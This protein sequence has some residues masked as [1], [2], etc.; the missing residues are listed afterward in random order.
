MFKA[1]FTKKWFCVIAAELVLFLI[2]ALF[3]SG[4]YSKTEITFSDSDMQLQGTEGDI[5]NGNYL[6][7]SFTEK[8]AVVTPAFQLKKGV[9]YFEASYAEQGI[10]KAGLIYDRTRNGQELVDNDE[11]ILN[12]ESSSISYRVN[13]HDDSALRFKIRLTGDASD[14]DYVQLL[15]VYIVSSRLT[16]V[17]QLFYLAVSFL[18]LD[19]MAWGYMSEYRKWDAKQKMVFITLA[20]TALLIGLPLC[21]KGLPDGP[22]LRFHLQRLEGVYKGLLSGQFPVRI[23]PGWLDGYGYASS[24]FYGD[25]FLYFPAFLR[26]AGF[27]LE[28]AYKCYIWGVA[29]VT[30]ML[31]FYAFKRI[32]KDDLAAMVGTLLYV[33]STEKLSIQYSARLGNYG[34]MMFYPLILAGFYLIFT[35]DEEKAEYKGLWKLLTFGFTGLL[36]THMQSCL[37]VGLYAV[38]G[39]IIM[40]KKVVRKKVFLE[41]LKA[42]GAAILL[43]LWYLVPF[44]NYML[45]ESLNINSAITDGEEIADYYVRL[46]DFMQGGE[47]LHSLIARPNYVDYAI[48]LILLLYIITIPMQKKNTA[49]KR[50]RIIFGLALSAFWACTDLFPAVKIAE[51]CSM[52]VKYFS[53]LQYQIRFISIAVTFAACLAAL[54]FVMDA[55]N[56]EKLYLVAGLLCCAMLYQDLHYFETVVSEVVYLSDADLNSRYGKSRYDYGIGN[57]EFLP[58]EID[59]QKLTMEV[60]AGEALQIENVLNEYLTYD[61]SVVNTSAREQEV[62]LPL[63]HYGGYETR[64]RESGAE[65]TTTAGDNGRVMVLIPA[66]YSGTF[67]TAFCEPWF[68]RLAEMASGITL[69][70]ILYCTIMKKCGRKLSGPF[71]KNMV[72]LD[73]AGLAE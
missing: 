9:Y 40:I 55:L 62:L 7:T 30:I 72:P 11:F 73:Q 41:L 36:M 31:S 46:A 16:F 34:A 48:L 50:S 70:F 51:I 63:L 59:T 61:I 47:S 64:D 5:S 28:G 26:M 23:Q 27:S 53:I 38:L 58:T 6:D 2:F 29:V 43:N 12:S 57:G 52:A 69:L 4:K 22:D 24:I 56:P 17:L 10:A 65:L 35:E 45:S 18:V 1:L 66:G 19:L 33:C 71:Y 68:W 54:F 15:Q 44:G 13:I 21:Q 32:S 3:L 60:E 37:L 42:V 25:I 14:G 8:K 39:C 49:T 20:L 67:H